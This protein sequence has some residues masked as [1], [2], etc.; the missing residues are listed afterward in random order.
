MTDMDSD[1]PAL[2]MGN[3]ILGGNYTSRLWERLRQQ[4]GLSYGA[5]SRLSIDSL[6]KDS[7]FSI[8]ATCNPINMDKL[9]NSALEE[10]RKIL[11]KGVTADELTASQK[12]FLESQKEQR[13]SDSHVAAVLREDLYLNR[14]MQF[15]ENVERKVESATVDEV[16]S[17]MRARLDP[18]RLV[19]V[20]SGSLNKK[21]P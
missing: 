13:G 3:A 20:R 6:D 21:S 14:T 16:N 10:F 15:T 4:E 17:A 18:T 19:I 7:Q 12:T 11:D 5:G 2:L 9:S 8:S 1:Y